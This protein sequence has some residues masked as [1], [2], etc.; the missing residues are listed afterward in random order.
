VGQNAIYVEVLNLFTEDT[1]PPPAILLEEFESV[2]SQG[3]VT[4]LRKGR[5]VRRIQ[6]YECRN[7]IMA[8]KP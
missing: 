3:S 4:V 2:T 5:P 6:I 1:Y 7:L 8:V